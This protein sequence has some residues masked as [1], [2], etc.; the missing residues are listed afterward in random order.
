M[1]RSHA[2]VVNQLSHRRQRLLKRGKHPCQALFSPLFQLHANCLSILLARRTLLLEDGGF[3][4]CLGSLLRL[5]LVVIFWVVF[6]RLLVIRCLLSTLLQCLVVWAPLFLGALHSVFAVL[7]SLLSVMPLCT[8]P[9]EDGALLLCSFP[10]PLFVLFSGICLLVCLRVCLFVFHLIQFLILS[11][12]CV[13]TRF[14]DS[15]S[16]PIGGFV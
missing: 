14:C 5:P 7:V 12:P 16:R 9:G 15:R 4:T 3:L 2:V 6:R 13:S 8:V 11:W 1:F 10:S